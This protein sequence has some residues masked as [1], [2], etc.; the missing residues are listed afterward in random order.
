MRGLRSFAALLVVLIGLG[1]Y[2][3][4]VES[5]RTPGDDEEKRDKV[6]AVEADKIDEI[7][8]KPVSGEPT[9]LRKSGNDWQIVQPAAA[10][11]DAGEISGL[12][13]SLSSLEIQRVVDE[14]APD[15]NEYGLEKP[16]LEVDFKSGGQ[17]H[18]LLIGA[19]TPPG[20]DLYARL[21]DQRKVFLIPSHLESTFNRN[22]FDLRDKT[23]LHVEREAIDNIEL[24][25]GGQTVKLSKG[26]A[27]WRV[28]EPV[29]VPADFSAINGLLSTLTSAQMK[30]IEA[31]PAAD[32]K[33]YGLDK[34]AA[35]VRVGSG[36]SRAA[37]LIGGPSTDGSV[38]A[39]DE[40]R[41]DI[42]TIESSLLT[43]LQKPASDY[44]Q[45]DLFDARV[46]NATRIEATRDGQTVAFERTKIKDKDGK[47]EE[48]WQQV[49]PSRKDVDGPKV[50]A[51]VSAATGAR[52]VSFVDDAARTPLSKPE[53]T[54]AIKHDNGAK[55]DRVAFARSRSDAYA[56]R[57]GSP[58]AARFEATTL[59]GI[60]KALD[61][62]K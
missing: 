49:L 55:E 8:I 39:R 30:S 62:L 24:S 33:K 3:Y 17:E 45:K 59:D 29:T 40:S 16:R 1:A 21:G 5:K 13:S 6:F 19:K 26:D 31:T 43:E 32:L 44:R 15:L 36:S 18:K 20:S 14:Q 57:Q 23:V 41:P 38:Y 35:T 10:R 54:L 53:L 42:F 51:L 47:E 9:T 50:E 7:T 37:L 28:V 27:E 4:F 22:T 11:P 34:P 25:S 12:T 61:A 58:G 2:L 52:A 60:I 46:F 48:K 56:A